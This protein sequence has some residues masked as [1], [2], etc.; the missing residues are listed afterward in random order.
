MSR[1]SSIRLSLAAR[2]RRICRTSFTS[3]AIGTSWIH[4]PLTAKRNQPHT[5]A[6]LRQRW[7]VGLRASSFLRQKARGRLCRLGRVARQALRTRLDSFVAT[8]PGSCMRQMLS[9][10]GPLETG[11]SFAT[12]TAEVERRSSAGTAIAMRQRWLDFAGMMTQVT[13]GLNVIDGRAPLQNLVLHRHLYPRQ[14][15][16]LVGGPDGVW[17][18]SAR[19]RLCHP[20]APGLGPMVRAYHSDGQCLHA[21]VRD[22]LI[23][24]L[25][26]DHHRLRNAIFNALS[27]HW[28][29]RIVR[30]LTFARLPGVQPF[31]ER[32]VP[33]EP[34]VDSGWRILPGP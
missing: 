15:T 3:R 21:V 28:E 29:R 7:D 22:H 13:G 20:R 33:Y 14:P 34:I 8:A 12:E 23:S 16:V 17:G 10:R 27:V 32:H 4:I 24:I 31:V 19:S 1:R 2:A 9:L 5:R 6:T 18:H 11:S 30:N 25:G 26:G